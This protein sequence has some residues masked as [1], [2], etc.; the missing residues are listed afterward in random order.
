MIIAYLY[1]RPVAEGAAM[2]AERTFA[3]YRGT[4]RK[5]LTDMVQRGGVRK[6][7]TLVL[8]A[9]SDLGQGAESKRLQKMI[10]DLGVWI[11][12]KPGPEGERVQGRKPRLKP[13]PEQKEHICALWYSPAP[14]DHVLSRASDIMGGEVDRNN[15][16]YWCGARDG[17]QRK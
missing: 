2:G 1:N 15:L 16:Y 10:T 8:R 13:T 11:E 9:L 6:G 5:E 14:V 4:G 12:V 17:S 3:D 7:D